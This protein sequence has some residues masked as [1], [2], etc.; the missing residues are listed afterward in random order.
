MVTLCT[1]LP[2]GEGAALGAQHSRFLGP[3]LNKVAPPRMDI[4]DPAL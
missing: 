4:I 2:L 3:C 1:A